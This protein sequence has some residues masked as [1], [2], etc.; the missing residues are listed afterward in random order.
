MPRDCDNTKIALFFSKEIIRETPLVGEIIVDEDPFITEWHYSLW[1]ELMSSLGED[2]VFWY[3]K[4]R[5]KDHPV[6]IENQMTWL[7]EA[8]FRHTA[9]HWRYLNFAIISG[10][11]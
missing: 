7:K 5:E 6:S 1:R 4:H 10:R 3:H 8:G 11:K 9:C 2:D